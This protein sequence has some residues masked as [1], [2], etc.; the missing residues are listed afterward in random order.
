MLL[1]HNAYVGEIWNFKMKINFR[2]FMTDVD[3]KGA[4]LRNISFLMIK[5]KK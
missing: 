4:I 5:K 1:R 3:Y 2:L